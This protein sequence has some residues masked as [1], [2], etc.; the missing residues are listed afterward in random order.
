MRFQRPPPLVY[1]SL[2]NSLPPRFVSLQ[3]DAT[4]GPTNWESCRGRARTPREAL[5]LLFFSKNSTRA[6]RTFI[7]ARRSSDRLRPLVAVESNL[8][9][10]TGTQIKRGASPFDTALSHASEIRAFPPGHPSP[11]SRGRSD[12]RTQ[13]RTL[14]KLANVARAARK[15]DGS[16]KYFGLH[17]GTGFPMQSWLNSAIY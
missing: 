8:S 13:H 7:V 11:R 16:P 1:R 2:T 14:M 5:T 9:A 17:R 15:T 10:N 4:R 3:R 12:P 6:S